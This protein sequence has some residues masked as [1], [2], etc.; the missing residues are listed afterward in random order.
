MSRN[1][2]RSRKRAKLTCD[3]FPRKGTGNLLRDLMSSVLILDKTVVVQQVPG[4]STSSS[5]DGWT[6][7]SSE[8]CSICGVVNQ[9]CVPFTPQEI[10]ILEEFVLKKVGANI[11][12]SFCVWICPPC[13]QTVRKIIKLMTEVENIITCLWTVIQF[14]LQDNQIS[15]NTG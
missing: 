2:S 4:Y 14:Q 6:S 5:K 9:A 10:G 13:S 7:K 12:T 8:S 3:P 11:S 15:T 1:G